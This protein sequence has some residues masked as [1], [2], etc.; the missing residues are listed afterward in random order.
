MDLFL[1]LSVLT[2][3]EFKKSTDCK[4]HWFHDV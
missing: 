1:A 3:T 4:A 2:A